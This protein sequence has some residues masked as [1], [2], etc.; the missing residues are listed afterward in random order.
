MR[1]VKFPAITILI[2]CAIRSA[3]FSYPQLKLLSVVF[4]HGDRE[5]NDDIGGDLTQ[6]GRLRAYRLGEILRVRY[7][8][9]LGEKYEPSRLYARST[10]YVRAKMSLQLLLAGLFVPRGQ[11][12]WRE[13][14]DWQPIPFSYARLKEDVLLFPRDCPSF[15]REMKRFLPSP[16]FQKL[17][18][19]YREMMRNMTIWMGQEMSIPNHMFVLYHK[20]SSMQALDEPLPEWSRDFFPYGLLLNGTYLEYDTHKYIDWMRRVNG[21]TL[22]RKMIDDM[23]NRTDE[24]YPGKRDVYLYSGHELNIVSI[25]QSLK[26]WQ[27]HIPEYSSA[28]IVELREDRKNYYV[29]VL[30]HKGIP[31]IFKEMQIPGCPSLCPLDRFIE[32]LS[33]N[34]PAYD[35]IICDDKPVKFE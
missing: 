35:E 17:L 28:V 26:I 9:F 33:D 16:G 34:L 22:V 3:G 18:D 21:G 2:E 32:L 20:L 15:Q 14:L 27:P 5:L 11:Q 25:L 12:R 8:D 13:S 6:V 1:G 24:K 31:P 7:G 10:E 29:K 4:R 30:Y 19:P 23:L